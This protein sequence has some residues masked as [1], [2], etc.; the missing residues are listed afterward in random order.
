MMTSAFLDE[1]N[2]YP[3]LETDDGQVWTQDSNGGYPY[4]VELY[5][6]TSINP[7]KV[8]DTVSGQSFYTLSGQ[9][10]A[11]PRKGINI[12]GGKKVIIR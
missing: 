3:M 9:R 5:N 10:L 8:K 7:P 6:T 4:I 1:L 12:V 2:L 11:A